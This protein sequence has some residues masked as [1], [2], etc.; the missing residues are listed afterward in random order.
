MTVTTGNK[1]AFQGALGAFSHDAGRKF[2]LSQQF[3]EPAFVPCNSFEEVFQQVATG[4]SALGIIPVENSSI[5]PISVNLDL[6]WRYDLNMIGEVLSPIHHNLIGLPGASLS[7]VTHAYSHP[8]ALE[9]CKKFFAENKQIEAV[10]YFDTSG[11]VQLVKDMQDPTVAAI[12]G[13]FAAREYKLQILKE[14]I[15]DYAGNTTRFAVICKDP[16]V[17][18]PSLDYKLSCAV[19]LAHEPGSL[20]K[21]LSRLAGLEVNLTKIESRPIPEQPWH[22]RFFIDIELNGYDQDVGIVKVLCDST[23]NHKILGRYQPWRQKD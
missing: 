8:A 5:G 13:D 22:Y 18:L 6:L 12:A 1:I 16:R 20:A 11:A 10:A 7:S 3:G 9:Q 2:A 23:E 4:H 14:N 17:E 21:L 15:E 19:E